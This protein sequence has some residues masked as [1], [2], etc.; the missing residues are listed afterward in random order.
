[1]IKLRHSVLFLA[2]GAA[3]LAA[4]TVTSTDSN[5]GGT[6]SAPPGDSG[7][8]SIPPG[9]VGDD[10]PPS[11]TPAPTNPDYSEPQTD[12]LL[13]LVAATPELATGTDFDFCW[14]QDSAAA[15]Y[16]GPVAKSY[17]SSLSA[18]EITK[19]FK[20]TGMVAD[21]PV[22]IRL[23][24]KDSPNCDLGNRFTSSAGFA[25][26]VTDDTTH[27]LKVG[28]NTAVIYGQATSP[29]YA[30]NSYV[31]Q[32]PTGKASTPVVQF[33]QALTGATLS[34]TL[35]DG[36]GKAFTLS[37]GAD[38]AYGSYFEIGL[39]ASYTTAVDIKTLE[40]SISG[41]TSFTF[42]PTGYSMYNGYYWMIA[43]DKSTT[44]KAY[45]CTPQV[46][47][48]ADKDIVQT[49]CTLVAPAG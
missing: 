15:T 16:N 22:L 13:R 28:Y 5:D 18:P 46:Q 36:T 26:A 39:G 8:D 31:Y 34:L 38:L 44:P 43:Y 19:F 40:F 1:M 9:D 21:K 37:G 7:T 48:A 14:K 27:M 29:G 20:L 4:C 17:N 11:D 32:D 24:K 45:V 42:N 10:T 41:G 2:I 30:L 6:D 35:K 25:L 3:A 12:V 49:G 33:F 23:V 47:I